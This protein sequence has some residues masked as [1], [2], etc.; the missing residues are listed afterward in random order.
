MSVMRYLLVFVVCLASAQTPADWKL[1]SR[2]AWFYVDSAL[3]PS[4]DRAVKLIT[5]RLRINLRLPEFFPPFDNPE[6]CDHEVRVEHLQPWIDPAQRAL[7]HAHAFH[8]RYYYSALAEAGAGTVD[9]HRA[10]VPR[11]FHRFAASVHYEV[12]HANPHHADV[13]NCPICGRIGEYA[14]AKGHLVENVHDPLGLELLV[15]GTIRGQPVRLED[16]ERR[17]FGSVQTGP[18]D[19]RVSVHELAGQSEGRNTARMAIIVFEPR[20]R[21][22]AAGTP[23]RSPS[24]A[25]SKS[26]VPAKP[27]P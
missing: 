4:H 27:T 23:A 6:G 3:A 10:G 8:M 21:G 25:S 20:D 2:D 18:A 22:V 13:E 14:E 9:L 17:P 16:W 26:P 15:R 11:K 7:Q 24:G 19:L 12:E 5:E 1:P